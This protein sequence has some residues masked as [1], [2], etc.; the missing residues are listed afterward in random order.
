MAWVDCYNTGVVA[1]RLAALPRWRQRL[2]AKATGPSAA[3]AEHASTF[4]NGATMVGR[5]PSE[6]ARTLGVDPSA[7]VRPWC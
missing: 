6:K 7:R 4:V 1:D 3:G 5:P 2:A